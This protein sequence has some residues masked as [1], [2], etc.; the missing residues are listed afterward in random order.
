MVCWMLTYV[1]ERKM[2]VVQTAV[3]WFIATDK[4]KMDRDQTTYQAYLSTLCTRGQV[5]L[6][7]AYGIYIACSVEQSATDKKETGTST[8]CPES[9][10][11]KKRFGQLCSSLGENPESLYDAFTKFEI[12]CSQKNLTETFEV[13]R[14]YAEQLPQE[15]GI[16]WSLGS[17]VRKSSGELANRIATDKMLNLVKANIVAT[18]LMNLPGKRMVVKVDPDASLPVMKL[19]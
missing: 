6:N 10:I 2:E 4:K 19:I 7:Y 15:T 3:A 13:S 5:L 1:I 14:L 11:F 8:M 12:D 17:I 18:K 9:R 16:V